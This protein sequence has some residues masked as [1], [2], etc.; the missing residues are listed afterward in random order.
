MRLPLLFLVCIPQLLTAQ[1]LADTFEE[2]TEDGVIIYVRNQ[3]YSPVTF[4]FQ[5]DLNNM[6]ASPADSLVRLVPP[7]V[8]RWPAYRLR[9]DPEAR[10]Y[11]Y[12]YEYAVN[13]GDHRADG[14]DAN[15]VYELPVAPGTT[16]T[17]NQGYNGRFSHQG[18]LAL[19]FNLEEG[20]P[21]HAARNGVVADVVDEH[22]RGCPNPRCERYENRV[23]VYHADGTFAVYAHLQQHSAQVARG[24]TVTAG[25]L[26][27]RAGATG[28][29]N[30]PHLHFSVYRQLMDGRRYVPTDFRYVPAGTRSTNATGARAQVLGRLEERGKYQRPASD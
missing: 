17:V 16:V 25:Q 18:A 11:G 21:V 13:V 10:E 8:E 29:A 26:L 12:G 24:D 23:V 20:A 1:V 15:Y 19:D 5:L 14:Y 6:Y 3:E 4:E 30:G 27:A 7:R 22:D 2:P 9:I 28:F